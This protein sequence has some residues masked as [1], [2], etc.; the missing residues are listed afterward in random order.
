LFPQVSLIGGS[1]FWE[2][3]ARGTLTAH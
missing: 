2:Q 1:E 3:E